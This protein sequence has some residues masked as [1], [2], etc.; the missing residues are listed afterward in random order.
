[1][2]ELFNTLSSSARFDKKKKRQRDQDDNGK[3][4][5][6]PPEA[7]LSHL[8]KEKLPSRDRTGKRDTSAEKQEQVHREQV[9]AFRRSM[10]I[11]ISNKDDQS[12]PDPISSFSEMSK[13]SW[14]IGDKDEETRFFRNT[15]RAILRNI[16]LGR[17][18]EPT[19]VQMQAIPT[20]MCRRDLIGAA[21]TGS[22]KS[23]AFIIPALFLSSAPENVF[24]KS[25]SGS[26]K[27]N[28]GSIRVLVIAPS[29]ELAAQ[30]HREVERL[31]T[32]KM[33]GLSAMLL[34]K[35]NSAHVIAGSAGGKHGLDALISTP[36]RLV[37]SIEKG[38]KLNSVRLAILDEADRLLDA[39]DGQNRSNSF[40]VESTT[41]IE[42]ENKADDGEAPLSAS[43]QTKTFLSQIDTILSEIPVSAVRALFSATVTTTVRSLSESIL[44][45]PVDVSVGKVG[46]AGANTDIEQKLTFVS[47][48]HGKLLAIRQLVLNGEIRPPVIVFLQ[49]QERAQALFEEL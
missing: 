14:W 37:D 47:N 38:L 22:G 12:V 23:G 44:R 1:M 48:E 18:K 2:E 30:L 19:P 29:L 9:A 31:G 20:L 5:P 10:G 46:S 33:G 28:S 39:A 34:S 13:P 17:W 35:T 27:S 8:T 32:G 25:A 15:H 43:T 49:S 45:N 42:V 3:V 4:E 36:L 6:A 40:G 16:E 21:P 41:E 26:I 24:Y 7:K 11:K